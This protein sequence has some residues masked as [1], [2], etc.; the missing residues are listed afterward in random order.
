MKNGLGNT[1]M[2]A[3]KMQY[4]K[5]ENLSGMLYLSHQTPSKNSDPQMSS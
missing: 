1:A 3:T 4:S 2:H 5:D